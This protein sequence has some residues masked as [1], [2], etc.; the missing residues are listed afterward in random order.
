MMSSVTRENYNTF[1]TCYRKYAEAVEVATSVAKKN[2]SQL[3]QDERRK[4]YDNLITTGERL[5][6]KFKAFEDC[7]SV[8]EMDNQIFIEAAQADLDYISAMDIVRMAMIG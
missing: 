8:P 7:E 5:V 4:A 3:P 1:T 2:I 6:A